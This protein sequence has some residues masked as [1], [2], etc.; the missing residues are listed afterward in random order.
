MVLENDKDLTY[1]QLLSKR[2][3]TPDF[4]VIAFS[5]NDKMLSEESRNTIKNISNELLRLEKVNSVNSIL[6]VPLLQSSNK[7]LADIL[8]GVPLLED[9]IVD[10]LD[11]KKEFLNSPLY[12]NNLVS[13]DFKTTAILVNLK[14]N[15]KLSNIRDQI[16]LLKKK[17][18]NNSITEDELK[19]YNDLITDLRNI[20][21][22]ERDVQTSLINDTRNILNKYK[23]F[24]EIYLGGIPMIANDVV[25]FVKNDLKIFGISILIFLI[26]ILFII[27]RQIRWVVLPII[28]CF[29]SVSI[30]AGLFSIF[31]WEV[32][33]IS[34]NFISLQLILTMAITIHLIVRYRELIVSKES[35]SQEKLLL[36]TVLQMIKP[37]FFTVITTIA[38]FSSLILSD[39]LP[40]INFG[41]M[42]S[43]GVSIS[44]L[45]TFL[46]FPVLLLEVSKIDPNLS[47]ENKFNLPELVAKF[48]N[49]YGTLSLVFAFVI[50]IFSLIGVTK[51]K[52]EN[53]FIDY[54]KSHT[55]INKGM[56]VIDEKLGGTT[57][58][59]V[60][61]DFENSKEAGQEKETTNL[62]EDFDDLLMEFEE[63]SNEAKYWF[64]DYKMTQIEKLHDYLNSLEETGKVLSFA[65]ILKIGRSINNGN[66]LD[67]VQL[68][69]LYEKLPQEYK[70]VIVDPFISTENNQAR[71]TLRVKDSDPKLRR[72]E[73]I[74]K[75]KKKL[76]KFFR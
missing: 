44:L 6:N 75:I 70:E 41:W 59:D 60:T 22:I 40:V 4:L 17:I 1:H 52:V 30:T 37:C 20:R 10:Y 21:D 31:N 15:N 57:I 73:L 38:G 12:K 5:P 67:S 76:L 43:L 69:L 25:S 51:L 63:E 64:T 71:I 47:F 2:Y 8:E 49:N 19:V 7:S 13:D 23:S 36:E 58:L 53:S 26:I 18:R 72:N 50:F 39:L 45:V 9:N 68:G 66:S 27:F 3:K 35:I 54:F 46:I 48:A 65:T 32:T 28:T 74:K 24:G 14:E 16:K 29:F 62:S 61:L 55:E 33:V 42:M 11:A 56:V 34:S